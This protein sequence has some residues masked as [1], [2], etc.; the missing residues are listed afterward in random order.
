MT[1]PAHCTLLEE[2]LNG[3]VA[4]AVLQGWT[5]RSGMCSSLSFSWQQHTSSICSIV[6]RQSKNLL[7][8][9]YCRGLNSSC[10][11]TGASVCAMGTTC[12]SV[13][14]ME[15]GKE[16]PPGAVCMFLLAGQSNMA[17]RA[18]ISEE[19]SEEPR[20]L[21]LSRDGKW[22]TA[23]DPLHDDKPEKAGVGPGLAFARA[24]VVAISVCRS[25]SYY[26]QDIA[27]YKLCKTVNDPKLTALGF[28]SKLC[29]LYYQDFCSAPI[30]LVPCAFGGS[31][32]QR[33]IASWC[34]LSIY[35]ARM[36]LV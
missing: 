1:S 16:P 2:S 15:S 7:I 11:P 29:K 9:F 18:Q 31:E 23:R 32:I 28:V 12:A 33:W 5:L 10:R 3:R 30:G 17:G 22:K 8:S 27:N 19:C 13:C 35:N 6:P 25:T 20:I 26:I 21:A 24:V 34:W 14:S 36:I 4:L